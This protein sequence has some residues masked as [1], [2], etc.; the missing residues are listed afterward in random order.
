[1]RTRNF[2]PN[3]LADRHMLTG[4]SKLWMAIAVGLT[5]AAASPGTAQ[6]QNTGCVK[7]GNT[8]DCDGVPTDG[9][10]YSSDVTS[11]NVDAANNTPT[12]VTSGTRG[13]SLTQSGGNP[14]TPAASVTYTTVDVVVGQDDDDN[15]IVWTVVAVPSTTTPPGDAVPV[16]REDEYVRKL[17]D[18][19]FAIGTTT[20]T[21][22]ALATELNSA[23]VDPGATV[24]G[25]LT[26]S[27]PG[28]GGSA[29]SFSTND[30]D[31][32]L[33]QSVGGG[34]GSGSCSTVLVYTW[35][36]NGGSGGNAGSVAVNNNG[37][38]TVTGSGYGVSATSQGGVGGNGGG[39]FG[40]FASSAG[41]GG[42][43]GNGG[44]VNVLLGANS[45][46]ATSGDGRHG[47]NA[48]SKGG[49]GG[50][51]GSSSGLVALGDKGGNGGDAGTVTVTNN[52][53]ITTTGVKAHAIYAQSIGA[54]AG[55]G[56]SSGGLVA[57][58][59]NGG[60]ES[61]GNTVTVTNNGAIETKGVDSFGIFAQSV[62]GGG[63]DGGTSGGLFSV[64][65]RAGSG[66]NGDVVKV[67][68][69]GSITTEKDG[70]VA[71][72]AQSVGGGGGNGGGA[73][74]VGQIGAVALGGEGGPGGDAGDVF[75]NDTEHLAELAAATITTN[76]SRAHGIQAQSV[77]GGGGSGGLAIAASTSSGASISASV[78]LGGTGGD[79][80]DGKKVTANATGTIATHG[81]ISHGVFA[82]SVGG[83][84]GSGGGAVSVAGGGQMSFSLALGGSGGKGGSADTVTVNTLAGGHITTTKAGSIGILAQSLGGGGGN[85]GFAGAGAAGPASL[86]IAL[87]GSGSEGGMGGIVTVNNGMSIETEGANATGIFAQSVGGGGGN[88]GFALGATIGVV[89]I[90][91]AVGGSGAGGGDGNS[92]HV[93]NSG[94]IATLGDLA[95]GI[96]AQSI[97]GGGGNGGAAVAVSA[98]FS[99]LPEVPAIGIAI[100]VGG[101]ADGGGDGGLV[102]V[103]NTGTIETRGIKTHGV[104]AQSVGGGGG[105]GGYAAAGTLSTGDI[106]GGI[107]VAVGGTGGEGGDGK[108]VTIG[109]DTNGLGLSGTSIT[110]YGEASDAIH[111]QSIG[112]GGGDGGFAVAINLSKT[113]PGGASL[114][115]G[116]SV[117]GSGGVAGNGGV[118]DIYTEQLLRTF[119]DNSAGV[120]GQS[121][122]GGGGNGGNAITGMVGVV[123]TTDPA[124]QAVSVAV[125]VGGSGGAGGDGDEVKVENHGD[126]ETGQVVLVDGAPVLVDGVPIVAGSNSAGIFAQSVGG[127][128]GNGGRANAINMIIGKGCGQ[129]CPPD[130]ALNV[131]LTVSV[132]GSGASAGDGGEVTVDNFGNIVTH[133]DTANG[134]FAQSVGGGGG[135]GGNG[136]LGSGELIPV[137]VDTLV[138]LAFGKTKQYAN[139]SVAVGGD[140]G[141]SGI[142]KAVDVNN[143]G[144]I[145]TYG[146]NSTAI[147]AQSVGGGGG[148]GGLASIGVT[149]KIG[150]GGKG[151]SGGDGGSVTVDQLNGAIIE[152]FGTAS[153]GILAQSVGGGGGL[154]GNV[155]RLLANGLGP[156][157]SLNVGVGLA[158]GQGGGNGGDGGDVKVT[159]DGVITTHGDSATA[160]FAHSVGG[161]GGIMGGLG[162]DLP[163]ANLLSWHIGSN[164]DVGD[165]GV[166]D[167][168]LDGT[169]QTSGNS[170]AGIFAQSSGG[171]GTG[172]NVTVT[173]AGTIETAA[174]LAEADGTIEDP[175]RGLGSIG[176]SAQSVGIGGNGD[177]TIKLTDV[178]GKV[179]GG[180]SDGDH[181][182]VAIMVIDGKDNT[183]TNYGVI[184]SFDVS[185]AGYAI[186][187]YGSNPDALGETTDGTLSVLEVGLGTQQAGGNEVVR[188]FGTLFGSFDLG[189]GT[190]SFTNESSGLLYSGRIAAVGDGLGLLNNGLMS[191]GGKDRVMTTNVTGTVTQGVNAVYFADLDMALSAASG[192]VDEDGTSDLY[193]ATGGIEMA[194][195]VQ[196]NLLNAGQARTGEHIAVIARSD[197]LFSGDGLTVAEAPGVVLSYWLDTS[198]SEL[199]LN[200]AIDFSPEGLDRNQA[201]IGEY[202]NALQNAGGT[203]A[204]APLI[205][206]LIYLPDMQAYAETLDQLSPEPYLV[207]QIAAYAAMSRF[208]NALMSCRTSGGDY[209]FAAEGECAW[210]SATAHS[211]TTTAT[212]LAIASEQR[213]IGMSGGLQVA[214][215]DVVRAGLGLSYTELAS[216]TATSAST[217]RLL[218]GA[219]VVKLQTGDTV[220]A[221]AAIGGYGSFDT[222]RL[223]S[224]VD[225]PSYMLEGE[226][227][228]GFVS[229]HV[230]LSHTFA[231]DSGYIRPSIDIGVTQATLF[232][233]EEAGGP[234]ALDIEAQTSLFVTALPAI[235]VGGEIAFGPGVVL[236]PFAKLGVQAPLVGRD[237][238]LTAGLT[239][240]PNGLDGFSISSVMDPYLI[241]L[242]L[243]F[244]LIRDD[245]FTLKLTGDAQI[246]ETQ[247]S[248]GGNLKLSSPF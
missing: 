230:R 165:A 234:I 157:P 55:S 104:F 45:V 80:G 122:G 148:V 177:I 105:Q 160:I 139:I 194:G 137:P 143:S 3:T 11:I 114:N 193:Q 68:N 70:A 214:L 27:N 188:N 33:V 31:G 44:D 211:S 92:V 184:S 47:V 158:L 231:G 99:P 228:I 130:P 222:S 13:I 43:G 174:L 67:T 238:T 75:V 69:S 93:D 41:R 123:D 208:E 9:I 229:G 111:A 161:G 6:A 15:D 176:I 170:A 97:G 164:G 224:I 121:V 54:G 77:G 94:S 159:V 187:A 173:V 21:G 66:G 16:M 132:G 155:D 100:A 226:Q 73:V 236:R 166:V 59:G 138:G 14:S 109:R 53:T 36:R 195:E 220:L 134:I 235:E 102:S 248:Y 223:F 34:G 124:S 202:I 88:G 197:T 62:G 246:G 42:D 116:V 247:R 108:L 172:G 96:Q 2:G 167:V 107:T 24:S 178:T 175:Q 12:P 190:N 86:A 120:F 84:G 125:A 71:I 78:S 182:G 129:S 232:G 126:I 205:N 216:E 240:A 218:Q 133:G 162:N 140:G 20:Y 215:N 233:F 57:F 144:N 63:G 154:A 48:Y 19:S 156:I 171:T 52:G 8:A 32:L 64:G 38:I 217:G 85:G 189:A 82:Q 76:G 150:V 90:S 18:D 199:L 10:S 7:D 149:G 245:G 180:R 168:Q 26:V 136:V 210:A 56:S 128:G 196:V 200:Y 212:D 192:E 241:D 58:G 30:A 113:P 203:E 209:R 74:A 145:T 101:S 244:D 39:S 29:A 60:G 117:G 152:T 5:L 163:G 201:S 50:S 181:T 207:N 243:G 227:E 91:A 4:A 131:A 115:V 28:S 213:S 81:E 169:I 46:I 110:T 151:T 179:Q 35:C 239:G 17:G 83:G 112:G 37:E 89:A 25:A 98:A 22:I 146:S 191:P 242:T 23:G 49:D 185:D 198:P 186:L 237:P 141:G 51:G 118:V 87:G 119:G 225:G 65:G 40:L 1:L 153:Y 127:G 183:I 204:L 142:G 72:F 206:A 106:S 219:G 61:S 221:L 135:T 95:Y 147:L 79:G 103:A